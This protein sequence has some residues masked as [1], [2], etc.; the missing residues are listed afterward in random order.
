MGGDPSEDDLIQMAIRQSEE[1]ENRRKNM[2]SD[3]D[4]QIR[5]AM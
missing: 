3:E 5:Q 4:E 2:A 1:E